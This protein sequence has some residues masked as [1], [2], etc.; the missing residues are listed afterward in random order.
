MKY[1]IRYQYIFQL[2][3]NVHRSEL[4]T[5]YTEE[6]GLIGKPI[7]VIEEGQKQN[8]F[9]KLKKLGINKTQLERITSLAKYREDGIID[10]EG[11]Y[12]K[13]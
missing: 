3:G 12:H 1:F 4:Y 5:N 7:C 2:G 9:S 11:K 6:N 13:W 10:L 8:M